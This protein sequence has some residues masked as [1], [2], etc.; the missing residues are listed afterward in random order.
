MEI[1]YQKRSQS[2]CGNL[3]NKGVRES[4]RE[5]AAQRGLRVYVRICYPRG[6][7]SLCGNLLPKG[8]QSQCKNSLPERVTE[9]TWEFA[10]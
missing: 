4:M 5:F 3:L 8:L 9:S 1:L 10:T 7:Q 6:S 2:L